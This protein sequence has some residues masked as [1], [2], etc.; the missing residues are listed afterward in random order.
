MCVAHG[1]GPDAPDDRE[2]PVK[3][4]RSLPERLLLAFSVVFGGVL[5]FLTPPFQAPDENSPHP[6]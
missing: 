2:N 5:V 1:G 6:G 3:V 4:K